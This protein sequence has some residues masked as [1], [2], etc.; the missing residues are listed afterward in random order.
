MCL[1]FTLTMFWHFNGAGG[2]DGSILSPVTRALMDLGG[3]SMIIY[4]YTALVRIIAAV[5]V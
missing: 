4:C 2:I 3:L 1:F 5:Y